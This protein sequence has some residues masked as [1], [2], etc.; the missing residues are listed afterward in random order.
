MTS[1][2]NLRPRTMPRATTPPAVT[3]NVSLKRTEAVSSALSA[4]S[5]NTPRRNGPSPIQEDTIQAE[6]HALKEKIKALKEKQDL[7]NLQKQES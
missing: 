2:R 3:E 4:A 1:E 6:T 7:I 5:V